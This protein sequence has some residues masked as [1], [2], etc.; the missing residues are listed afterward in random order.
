MAADL[1]GW[2]RLRGQL[3]PADAAQHIN[4][5]NQYFTGQSVDIIKAYVLVDDN[6]QVQGF[7][8]LNIRNFAEGSRSP[9]VP[10]VEAWYVSPVYQG[11]GWGKQFMHKAEQWALKMGHHELASDT[12]ISNQLSINIHKHLGFVETERIVCLLKQLKP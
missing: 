7:M 11:Q 9:Q 2:A 12:E 10:Y 5:L 6:R 1:A 3:W 8:E 4:E